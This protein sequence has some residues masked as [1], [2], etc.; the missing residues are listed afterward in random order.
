MNRAVDTGSWVERNHARLRRMYLRPQNHHAEQRA[1]ARVR[2]AEIRDSV[3]P[4]EWKL[5]LAVAAGVAYHQMT[6]TAAGAART[7]V[8]RLRA[9]LRPA[10]CRQLA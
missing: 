4:T 3:S 5:L 8:A 7:Q 2:L 9:R 6:G 1:L 10:E